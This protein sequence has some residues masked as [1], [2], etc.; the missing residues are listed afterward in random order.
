MSV[1]LVK[2]LMHECAV[3]VGC[4]CMSGS[5]HMSACSFISGRAKAQVFR[6]IG[7]QMHEWARVH[8]SM[9][10]QKL[11]GQSTY[12]QRHRCAES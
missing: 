4:R 11:A 8:V 1:E 5:G 3:G 10:L 2:W 7:V 6:V 9:Q 12:I